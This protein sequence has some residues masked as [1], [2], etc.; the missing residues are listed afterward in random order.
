[1]VVV[2]M[3]PA[4]AGKSTI[5]HALAGRLRWSFV[6]ADDLHSPASVATRAQGIP[7]DD[8]DRASWLDRVNGA[9]RTAA[10]NGSDLVV[11]CSALRERYRA[12]LTRKVPDVRWVFLRATRALLHERLATRRGHFAGPALLDTQL[13]ALEPPVG[14]IEIDAASPIDAIVDDICRALQLPSAVRS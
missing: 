11:A 8:A 12:Q 1:M 4:G 2:L 10:A 9:M 14:A 13:M 6:D 5:G 7:L 3:G